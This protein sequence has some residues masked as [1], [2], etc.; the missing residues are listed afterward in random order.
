MRRSHLY[1][2]VIHHHFRLE[3]GCRGEDELPESETQRPKR[4]EDMKTP[5]PC[6]ASMPPLEYN[7]LQA[8]KNE[9]EAC[10][11][12]L[13]EAVQKGLHSQHLI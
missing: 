5:L 1:S 8:F 12:G 10:A 11:L 4:D 7:S 13:T 9:I 2:L 6:A 3:R